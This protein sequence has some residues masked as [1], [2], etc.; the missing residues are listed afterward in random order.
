VFVQVLYL[1]ACKTCPFVVHTGKHHITVP[2]WRNKENSIVDQM[3]RYFIGDDP[4]IKDI[5]YLS[6]PQ[7]LD[8]RV[9]VYMCVYMYELCNVMLI[10]N[11]SPMIFISAHT[12]PQYINNQE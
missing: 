8:V 12:R 1:H 6:C 10:V 2:G 4:L 3:R 5:T 11:S 9:C 7:N